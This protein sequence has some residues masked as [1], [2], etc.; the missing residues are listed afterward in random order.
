MKEEKH[1]PIQSI[2]LKLSSTCSL[3]GTFEHY[4]HSYLAAAYVDAISHKDSEK[5]TFATNLAFKHMGLDSMSDGARKVIHGMTRWAKALRLEIRKRRDL[6]TK[7]EAKQH[8][9][10]SQKKG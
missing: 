2:Q 4:Q 1:S 6:L 10:D 3:R 8:K 7:L 9:K 5:T